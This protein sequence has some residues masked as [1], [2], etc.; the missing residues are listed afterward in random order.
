MSLAGTVENFSCLYV[1]KILISS[2]DLGKC[3]FNYG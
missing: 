3:G 2:V 1:G